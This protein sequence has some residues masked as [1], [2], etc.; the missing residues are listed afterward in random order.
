MESREHVMYRVYVYFKLVSVSLTTT[1]GQFCGAY[2][3]DFGVCL[4]YR[5][6][7]IWSGAVYNHSGVIFG[8]R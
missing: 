1:T 6:E 2:F 3:S 5:G 4:N 8:F 7:S